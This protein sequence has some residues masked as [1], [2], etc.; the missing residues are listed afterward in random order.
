M[1]DDKPQKV[2]LHIDG[3]AFFASVYQAIHPE[4]KG[5]PVV[6]GYERGIATAFSYEAKKRGVKRGMMVSEIKRICP[7]C[8]IA[9]SDYRVYQL[10][11]NRMAQIV[12][13]YTPDIERYSVDEV[14]ADITGCDRIH[15]TSYE[16]LAHIIKRKVEL[17]LDITV[18]V[19]VS[20]TKTLTKIA[21]NAHKPSGCTVLNTENIDDYLRS[22]D[23]GDIWGIGYRLADRFKVLKIHTA[24]D[25]VHT[26]ESLLRT[27]FNKMVMQTWYELQGVPIYALATGKK[28]DYQSIQKSSTVTPPVR[29]KDLLYTR[30]SHH[31]ENAFVKARK[32]NYRVHSIDIFL[33]TQKFTYASTTIK[34]HAPI[35][36]PYLIRKEIHAAF[37]K[38]YRTGVDYRATGC[39]LH[40]FE[41]TS[42]TQE[43]LFDER[44]ALEKKLKNIY[45]LYEKRLIGFGSD[46]RETK[47]FV[48]KSLLRAPQIVKMI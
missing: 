36:Y 48:R 7:D 35:E 45:P 11:S 42:V 38:I 25:F 23:I 30:V 22:T 43:E 14:F 9:S 44:S 24:Y 34:L 29:D 31:I 1:S 5:K 39:T 20:S 13:D 12:G 18:S 17:S 37:E 32:Y 4:T 16:H 33:K 40:N 21:S 15:H 27:N 26:P 28:E 47:K 19:G 6:I 3:D 46:L 2:F 10:F 8:I 41:S